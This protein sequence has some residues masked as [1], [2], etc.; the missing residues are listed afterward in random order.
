MKGRTPALAVLATGFVLVV[1]AQLI[2]PLR[3]PPLYDGVVIEE[4]YRYLSPPPG[5]PGSPTSYEQTLP[6][7]GGA[8]PSAVAATQ[9]SPPQAQMIADTGAFTLPLGT[10]NIVASIGAVLPPNAPSSGSILGN[11]YRFSVTNQEGTPLIAS[12]AV[13]IVLRAPSGS[14]QPIVARYTGSA[15]Q[16]LQTEHAGQQDLWLA[17]TTQLGDLT[18]IGRSTSGPFGLDPILVIAGGAAGAVSVLILFVVLWRTRRRPVPQPVGRRS[19]RALSRRKRGT[20]R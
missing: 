8:S 3:S 6:L 17:N 14:I 20:R 12:T 19:A 10:T 16:E 7:D 1:A 13:T 11:V 9:E 18:L 2:A 5:Q 4:P 15:W